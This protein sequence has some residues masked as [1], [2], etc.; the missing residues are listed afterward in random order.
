M[1]T[2]FVDPEKPGPWETWKTWILEK[3]GFW[4]HAN[5]DKYGILK[6]GLTLESY[7]FQRPF[8]MWFVGKLLFR[9]PY[10]DRHPSFDGH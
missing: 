1:K 7:N 3:L 6:I 9:R 5:S 8:T 2:C 10:T 4:K